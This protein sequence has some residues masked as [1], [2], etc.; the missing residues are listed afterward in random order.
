MGEGTKT[1]NRNCL[2]L[3]KG[4][5]K[6][7]I[8]F[9]SYF[10]LTPFYLLPHFRSSSLPGPFFPFTPDVIVK[11]LYEVSAASLGKQK[12]RRELKRSLRDK[13]VSRRDG[14]ATLRDKQQSLRD[15]Q[16]LP[17][18]RAETRRAG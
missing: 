12:V 5:N 15:G 8:T 2:Q 4:T 17:D 11:T 6:F 18:K 1:F 9:T 14:H 13:Q 10:C 3:T 16:D 7:G